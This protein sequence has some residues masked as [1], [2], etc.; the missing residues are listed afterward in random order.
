MTPSESLKP[1]V[2]IGVPVYNGEKYLQRALDSLAA[3][4]YPNLEIIISDN[5]S[6]DET[7]SICQR[8]AAADNRV[9]Y[10]RM[11]QRLSA[12]ENFR[13]VFDQHTGDYFMWAADDDVRSSNYVESLVRGFECNP[14][15]AIVY[16][17]IARFADDFRAAV[18]DPQFVDM[19]RDLSGFE[20]ILHHAKHHICVHI[21]GLIRCDLMTGYRWYSVD[22]GPDVPLLCHLAAR[23]EFVYVPGATFFSH[24]T[25]RSH[26]ATARRLLHRNMRAF[27]FAR[28]YWACADVAVNANNELGLRHSRGFYFLWLWFAYRW[29]NWK[30]HLFH[31]MPSSLQRF[32]S[33]SRRF[34]RSK[35]LTAR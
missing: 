9:R 20:R 8:F 35:G 33:N 22:L 28:L 7:P 21:Y 15:A 25:V 14:D 6:T 16:S 27:P 13:F 30:W 31:K 12:V 10:L 32:W 23:G 4:T 26:Q 2:T 3:Q 24:V 19:F 1:L 5:A 18:P 29:A 17:D 11:S 34:M